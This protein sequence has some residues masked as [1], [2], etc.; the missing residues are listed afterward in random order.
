MSKRGLVRRCIR[1]VFL[2]SILSSCGTVRA[3]SDIYDLMGDAGLIESTIHISSE[4]GVLLDCNVPL[5]SPNISLPAAIN[6]GLCSHPSLRQ[7]WSVAKARAAQLGL[8]KAAQ[9][10]TLTFGGQLIRS[11]PK[12]T[13]VDSDVPPIQRNQEQQNLSVAINWLIYDSGLR[14]ANE[15]AAAYTLQAAK[16]TQRDR[17]FGLIFDIGKSYFEWWASV[18]A[19]KAARRAEVFSEGLLEIARAKKSAGAATV[20]DPL[21]A[22]A[23]LSKAKFERVTAE[24]VEGGALASLA[25]LIGVAPSTL[26]NARPTRLSHLKWLEKPTDEI[27][28][29]ALERSGAVRA[30]NSQVRV[31]QARVRAAEAANGLTTSVGLNFARNLQK[32]DAIG[33]SYLLKVPLASVQMTLPLFD[34]GARDYQRHFALSQLEVALGALEAARR[35]VELDT[36]KA[37]VTLRKQRE[38]LA[39]AQALSRSATLA[40]EVAEKRYRAGVGNIQDVLS[41]KGSATTAAQ[42]A[43]A[44]TAELEAIR[45]KLLVL[46]MQPIVWEENPSEAREPH[47]K[48]E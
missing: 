45:L 9:S 17:V 46:T 12:T 7:L 48:L 37:D 31:M 38:Q 15:S 28:S 32:S 21:R 11:Q 44:A 22:E 23:E 41:T 39:A 42:E 8:A 43:I 24:S 33:Q 34:G 14:S 35:Q 4:M 5:P 29:I 13:F 3:Q 2:A 1:Y 10:P 27:S 36:W 6:S 47:L 40:A 26:A 19:V 16:E 18:A 30:A 25:T 20:L